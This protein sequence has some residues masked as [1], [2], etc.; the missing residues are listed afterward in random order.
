[1]AIILNISETGLLLETLVK[2]EVGETLHV[3]IPEAPS[4]AIRII[5]TEGLLAGCEFVRPVSTGTVSAAQLKASAGSGQGPAL[6]PGRRSAPGD[7]D[8]DERNFEKTIVS[9]S[10]LIT[11][12]ALLIFLAAI[13]PL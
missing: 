10:A 8:R 1:M 11:V 6:E 9:I 12:V 7:Y 13:V 4:S 3:D 2:L 5:W